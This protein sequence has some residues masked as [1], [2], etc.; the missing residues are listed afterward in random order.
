MKKEKQLNYIISVIAVLINVIVITNSIVHDPLIG[1]DADSH[2]D[3]ITVVADHL[4]TKSESGEYYSPPLPYII[5]GIA[6]K[7]CALLSNTDFI[8]LL[9]CK[10]LSGHIAQGINAI[11]AIFITLL[12][13]KISELIKQGNKYFRISTLMIFGGLTVFY[14]TFSQVRG[15]P[16]V[17]FFTLLVTFIMLK[18]YKDQKLFTWKASGLIGLILGLL[19]LSRQWGFLIF[20]AIFFFLLV[21]AVRKSSVSIGKRITIIIFTFLFAALV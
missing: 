14:K 11:L 12:L 21:A 13:I 8:S 6:Y 3:Y 1:Y 10:L 2:L 18:L 4:P 20:P 19:A 17:A 7:S 16:Y 15:E 5:P 9:R